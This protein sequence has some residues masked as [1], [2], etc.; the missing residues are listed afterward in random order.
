MSPDALNSAVPIEKLTPMLRQYVQLK[1]ERAA[2]ARGRVYEAYSEDAETI[3]REL[4]IT[5]FLNGTRSWITL[6]C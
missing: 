6:C 2:H 3:A 4:N 1:N 5:L